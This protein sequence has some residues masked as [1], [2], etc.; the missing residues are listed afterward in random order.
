MQG[1]RFFSIGNSGLN[2]RI[3]ESISNMSLVYL[4][5]CTLV[6]SSMSRESAASNFAVSNFRLV[7]SKICYF[8]FRYLEFSRKIVNFSL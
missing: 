6:Q 5:T 3:I 4:H 2:G 8:E 7:T 1:I